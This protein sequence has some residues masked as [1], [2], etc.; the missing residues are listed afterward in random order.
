MLPAKPED[1]VGEVY[2]DLVLEN[3]DDWRDARRGRLSDDSV[4][5]IRTRALVDTGAGML[6]LPREIVEQLGLEHMGT[7]IAEYA[8]G[9]RIDIDSAGIVR[10]TV[11]GRFAEVR[12]LVGPPGTEPLLGQLV[13]EITDLLVDCSRGELVPRPDSPRVPSYKVK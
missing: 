6:V 7:S 1:Y 4:R 2:A 11:A 5:S 8:D 3:H 13:L 10:V 9:R 12:C